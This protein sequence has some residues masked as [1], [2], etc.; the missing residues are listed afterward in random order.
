M[1][2]QQQM[3]SQRCTQEQVRRACLVD[4]PICAH[5]DMMR[6]CMTSSQ[7]ELGK[8][9]TSLS[10]RQAVYALRHTK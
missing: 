9:V 2:R 4:G 10:G 5:K 6:E 8:D 3:C 7:Q 1:P